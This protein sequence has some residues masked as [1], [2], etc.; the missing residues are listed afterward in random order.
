[1]THFCINESIDSLIFFFCVGMDRKAQGRTEKDRK[2]QGRTGMD[3]GKDEEGRESTGK[4][5][6]LDRKPH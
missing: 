3:T 4:T 5:A 1:M 2:A 6:G